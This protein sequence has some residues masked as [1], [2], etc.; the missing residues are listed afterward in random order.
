[1]EQFGA[2]N[3][4][5][6]DCPIPSEP[7]LPSGIICS[8]QLLCAECLPGQTFT[9]GRHLWVHLSS[10]RVQLGN[11]VVHRYKAYSPIGALLVTEGGYFSPSVQLLFLNQLRIWAEKMDAV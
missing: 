9:S 5:Y 4:I 6:W 7:N 1:M 2:K 11:P 10:P 3:Q 8:A